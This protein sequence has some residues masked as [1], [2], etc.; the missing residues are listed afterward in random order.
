M[1]CGFLGD[2]AAVL[3]RGLPLVPLHHGD[4]LHDG[5]VLIRHNLE[6][7]ALLALVLAGD[8]HHAVALLDLEL[9]HLQDLR[10]ERYDL[11]V[12]LGSQLAGDRAE[13]ARADRLAL[14][15]DQH[16]GVAV[17]ANDRAVGAAH[18]GSGAHHHGLHHLALLDAAA[19][20]RLLHG[21]YDGVA[22]R[23]VFA[24]RTA[25]HLDA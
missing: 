18:A 4:A 19:R 15:I 13:D 2:D 23:S 6:H 14:R 25:Q 22:D 7:L 17:E 24:L 12:L 16:G 8:D 3:G 21:D 1:D 10:R 11:H 9:G 5:A 20:Y